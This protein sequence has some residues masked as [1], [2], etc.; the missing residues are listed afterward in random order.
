[1]LTVVQR[2]RWKHSPNAK[3]PGHCSNNR[4]QQNLSRPIITYA[5]TE[6]LT[7]DYIQRTIDYWGLGYEKQ[8]AGVCLCIGLFIHTFWPTLK[9]HF[10]LLQSY[11]VK[12]A[13]HGWRLNNNKNRNYNLG[14]L[15][16]N[17]CEQLMLLKWMPPR[18]V[19]NESLVTCI[20]QH[21]IN[22]IIIC[23]MHRDVWL[24]SKETK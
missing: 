17:R 1:M 2:I 18:R 12:T 8:E 24:M 6:S 3:Y 20:V 4:K 23:F 19:T 9:W 16:T 15:C 13:D 10:S 11:I 22:G 14:W 5:L 21:V 7:I